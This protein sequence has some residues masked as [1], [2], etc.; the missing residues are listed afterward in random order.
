MSELDDVPIDEPVVHRNANDVESIVPLI[1]KLDPKWQAGTPLVDSP[2]HWTPHLVR[3]EK[4]WALHVH[5][6]LG[7]PRYLRK[8]LVAAAESG[9][10]IHLA[11]SLEALYVPEVLEVLGEADAYVYVIGQDAKPTPRR[12][13][14][15][16][17][18]DLGVPV[19]PTLRAQLARTAWEVR[20]RGT[21]NQRGRRLEAL[22]AFILGQVT[23]FRVFKRNFRTDTGEIDIVLQIDNF[24][25]RCWNESGVPFVF[26]ESKNVKDPIGQPV[27]SLLIRRLQT[28]RSRARI[29]LLFSAGDF[30]S[31][32]Q[33]EE[34]RLSESSLCVDF[35]G[36]S[37]IEALIAAEDIDSFLND[38]IGHAMLR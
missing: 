13:Y 34:L 11:L 4:R 19:D 5:L 18:A 36:P 28:S 3:P 17:L 22:L 8:R 37:D 14:L 21:V 24:G 35:F 16:A 9:E 6:S 38:H 15:A 25:G 23:D 1:K 32:A 27:V 33:R 10:L 30:T 2:I 29:G 7:A 31:D 20:D 26:V 12:H